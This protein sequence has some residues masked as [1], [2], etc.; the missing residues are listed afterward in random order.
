M[1]PKVERKTKESTLET[2]AKG[3]KTQRDRSQPT[4]LRGGAQKSQ[5]VAT[6]KTK[7]VKKNGNPSADGASEEEKF[8]GEPLLYVDVNF[9]GN[10]KTRIALYEKSNPEK[11]AKDFVK[12]HGL[13]SQIMQNLTNLLKE[14]LASALTNIDEEEDPSDKDHSTD[15]FADN[16]TAASPVKHQ[17][18][19]Q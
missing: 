5:E 8:E 12:K 2:T 11:V 10:E 1:S 18:I 14:Q 16:K 19:A 9:G 4:T 7:Q 13:D 3:F 15:D 6:N 17:V